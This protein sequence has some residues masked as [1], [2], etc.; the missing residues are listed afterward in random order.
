[1]RVYGHTYIPADSCIPGD[2]SSLGIHVCQGIHV[3]P[4]IHVIHCHPLLSSLTNLHQTLIH[5]QKLGIDGKRPKL[6]SGG[7]EGSSGEVSANRF[8]IS[9]RG[10]NFGGPP[11]T[12]LAPTILRVPTGATS[13]TAG[14]MSELP[15]TGR[16]NTTYSTNR[17]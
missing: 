16:V 10:T 7:I 6:I 8:R 4:W 12:L 15:S 9:G 11:K 14:K 17:C 2:A 5:S 13:D 1:M 3:V